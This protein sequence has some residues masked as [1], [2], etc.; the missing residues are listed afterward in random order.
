MGDMVADFSG[1]TVIKHISTL[2][3][4]NL[5][6]IRCELLVQV[7]CVQSSISSESNAYVYVNGEDD[8]VQ[9]SSNGCERLALLCCSVR[10][11]S[12]VS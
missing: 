7:P 3:Q 4:N 11:E 1:Q 9:V 12:T 10:S 8:E 6:N 2:I 5:Q